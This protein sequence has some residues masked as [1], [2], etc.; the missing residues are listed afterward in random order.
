MARQHA[1][2]NSARLAATQGTPRAADAEHAALVEAIA[3][4]DPAAARAAA[5]AHLTAAAARMGL[6]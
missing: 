4:G 5:R 1:W 6:A 3:A 2:E